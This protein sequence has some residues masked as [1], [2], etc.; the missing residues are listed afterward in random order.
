MAERK[1]AQPAPDHAETLPFEASP[2][3]RA[4]S[5]DS[6]FHVDSQSPTPCCRSLSSDFKATQVTEPSPGVMLEL[7][8]QIVKTV[9]PPMCTFGLLFWIVLAP[10]AS[11]NRW[12]FKT[13]WLPFSG[14]AHAP[15]ELLL[16]S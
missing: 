15:R 11:I 4:L 7:R 13:S 1:I 8:N 10:I 9:R 12:I 5:K 6:V 3:A 2:I 14:R 16:E